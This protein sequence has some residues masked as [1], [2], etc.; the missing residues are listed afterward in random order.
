MPL[1]NLKELKEDMK[2]KDW[3]ICCF[4]FQ[5]KG[6]DY[7][8]LVK[9]FV[10]NEERLSK[11]ALV[12]LHFMK[13]GNLE[14][15]LKAEANSQ[16][17]LIKVEKLRSY[18]NIEYGE[19]LGDILRQFTQRLNES[20]P[21]SVPE[22]ISSIQK[23]AMVRSLSKSDSEDPRKIFCNK[24]K[25]NPEG[26]KRSPFNS[27]KTKLLRPTLFEHFKD[28]LSI[29]FCYYVEKSKEHD[30]ETILKNFAKSSI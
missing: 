10:G 6:T 13:C 26:G 24:V 30:D 17:L 1:N 4:M 5:Y 7:V 15:D 29:S 21:V 14:D 20:I 2:K 18:F 8:V 23:E 3:T 12:K 19:N 11:Y 22:D 9:R 27:D 16:K 25:R 28:E